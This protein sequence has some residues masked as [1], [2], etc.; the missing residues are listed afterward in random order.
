MGLWEKFKSSF[1]GETTDTVQKVDS[2]KFYEGANTE[3]KPKAH[4]ETIA[5]VASNSN[6]TE[7]YEMAMNY[8][9]V[10]HGEYK[11][12]LPKAIK[13][14]EKAAECKHPDAIICLAEMYLSGMGCRKD[15]VRGLEYLQIAEKLCVDRSLKLLAIHYGTSNIAKA[16]TYYERYF[17]TGYFIDNQKVEIECVKEY[18]E[19]L[20]RNNNTINNKFINKYKA[21]IINLYKRWY[22]DYSEWEHNDDSSDYTDEK[23]HIKKMIKLLD[24][25]YKFPS[26]KNIYFKANKNN[27]DDFLESLSLGACKNK[28]DDSFETAEAYY[29]GLGDE[30]QDYKEAIIYYKKAEKAG[31]PEA[32]LQLGLM[33]KKGEGCGQDYEQ[34]LDYFKGGVKRGE[35]RC[36]AEMGD[37]FA[38]LD[39]AANSI[40]CWTKYFNSPSFDNGLGS[41]ANYAL[42]YITNQFVYKIELTNEISIKIISIKDEIVQ[43]CDDLISKA[44]T[45]E[46]DLPPESDDDSLAGI[47]SFYINVKNMLA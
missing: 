46:R 45:I 5:K 23:Q 25:S 15:N 26:N 18:F 35:D 8:Y 38:I 40:K 1:G 28:W 29:Y 44:E 42:S 16:L 12:D 30:I 32:C 27:D 43:Q 34:A 2:A 19:L 17:E 47:I 22:D 14:F 6:P 3:L 31:S 39:N 4:S 36:Y 13:L 33:C 9:Q 37:L 7:T 41:R 20:I 24:P 11:Q 10:S 21:D